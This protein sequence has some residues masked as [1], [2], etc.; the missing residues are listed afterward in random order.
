MKY[1]Y[2]KPNKAKLEQHR[3]QQQQQQHQQRWDDTTTND[4]ANDDDTKYNAAVQDFIQRKIASDPGYFAKRLEQRHYELCQSCP[5]PQAITVRLSL[6]VLPLQ[7]HV[8][9]SALVGCSSSLTAAAIRDTIV[10]RINHYWQPQAGISFQLLAVLDRPCTLGPTIERDLHHFITHKLK[11][12]PDGK[13]LH[14]KERRIKFYDVLISSFLPNNNNNNS[15]NNNSNNNSNGS[16]LT[17]TTKKKNI[18]TAFT[19]DIWFM[20]MVGDGSQGQCIDRKT[21]TIMMGERSTKGYDTPTK[22]PHPCLGKTAAHE[23]GHALGLNHPYG[24][25][26]EDG[27]PQLLLSRSSSNRRGRRPP[28]RNLMEGGSDRNGGGGSYLEQWQCS[29]ARESA[30]HFLRKLKQQ[31]QQ[32]QK[33]NRTLKTTNTEERESKLVETV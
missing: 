27:N 33:E 16:S 23:L 26:F 18:T 11:R 14:K 31:Q 4:N 22:R 8:I 6:L 29:I 12:G 17:T 1:I 28:R 30:H 15:N 10:E 21:R 32:L 19:Y 9:R 24:Q 3:Q 25:F 20:D 2:K 7:I 5:L 13:M